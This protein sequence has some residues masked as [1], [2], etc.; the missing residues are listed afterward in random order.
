MIRRLRW[1][2]VAINMAMVTAV[3]LAVFAGVLLSSR[4]AVERSVNQR[5]LQVIQTGR[6]DASLPG[7]GS[8]PCFVADIYPSGT[9]RLSGSSYYQLDDQDAMAEIVTACLEQGSESGVLRAYH[10]RYLRADGPLY[11]RIAF[12][13]AAQ[14]DATLR[15]VVKMCLIVGVAALAVLLGCSWLLA[16]LAA[17]PVARSLDQQRRFL[18][19]AS[20]E[21]KTPLTVILSS[22]DLMQQ[23]DVQPDQQP[24]VDNIRWSGPTTG[25]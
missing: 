22:A 13:D 5:L 18:S 1:K 21:L 16:G 4:A 19:D 2:I 25:G 8:A 24:Y 7:Q 6:Y 17:R 11:T 15:A 20:H 3:L 14:E 9:V 23:T 12:T 10:L